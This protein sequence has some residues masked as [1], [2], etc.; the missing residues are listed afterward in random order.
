MALDEFSAYTEALAAWLASNRQDELQLLQGRALEDAKELAR[1]QSLSESDY[2]FLIASQELE[3]REL[4]KQLEIAQQATQD[5]NQQIADF[6]AN[7]RTELATPI[8]SII[9]Y[10]I[11]IK[12]GLADSREE[13]QEFINEA[14]QTAL[15]TLNR[16]NGLLDV[17]KLARLKADKFYLDRE[18][19]KLAE[20]L[21][22]VEN[23]L[24][25]QAHEKQLNFQLISSATHG[26]IITYGDSFQL[27]QVLLNLVGDAITHTDE[28]GITIV[29]EMSEHK[30]VLQNQEHPRLFKIHVDDNRNMYSQDELLRFFRQT[31][32]SSI[33]QWCHTPVS[34]LAM[35]KKLIEAMNGELHLALKGDGSGAIITISLPL[36]QEPVMKG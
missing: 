25:A 21:T 7:T 11:L 24:R 8:N 27:R 20:L 30:V 32:D 1:S 22:E 16:V 15:D 14:H 10:L 3:K 18:S 6:L 17:A 19:I 34:G 2:Q 26:E 5:V 23:S 35:S 31:N 12:D 29:V 4:L 9:G 13:E 36:Y 28:G 33:F